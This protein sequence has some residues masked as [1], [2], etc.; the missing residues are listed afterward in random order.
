VL[1]FIIFAAAEVIEGHLFK[2]A[3]FLLLSGL[4]H[5]ALA[6]QMALIVAAFYFLQYRFREFKSLLKCILLLSV[7]MA[8]CVAP[9]LILRFVN[10]DQLSV[11]ELMSGMRQNFHINSLSLKLFLNYRIPTFVG[12]MAV[13]VQ[14]MRHHKKFIPNFL[15]F[16][17][18]SLITTILFAFLHLAGFIWSVPRLLQL[19][20]L[21]STLI[22]IMLT[23]PLPVTYLVDKILSDRFLN[24]CIAASILF[25]FSL[26][27]WGFFW[28]PLLALLLTDISEGHL[29]IFKFDLKR[30][31]QS[32]FYKA[33]KVIFL[34]W[35][36]IV[37]AWGAYAVLGG[38]DISSQ[39]FMSI[40]IP[41]ALINAKGY[42]CALTFAVVVGLSGW[43]PFGSL[44]K[45]WQRLTQSVRFSYGLISRLNNFMT[46]FHSHY[47]PVYLLTAILI[48][49]AVSKA[50]KIGRETIQPAAR[51]NYAAQLW[52]RY[53]TA[54]DAKFLVLI[55]VPWRTVSIRNTIFLDS[56]R[57]YIYSVSRQGKKIFDEI[58]RFIRE[59][60]PA[61]KKI[62]E[63]DALRMAEHFGRDYIVC[64]RD[65]PLNLSEVYRNDYVVIYK[66]SKS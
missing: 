36:V 11:S 4:I 66:I 1:P 63:V 59:I 40:L 27:G 3:F 13:T 52:A 25:L 6:I 60:N 16:C 21:R 65:N 55:A 46:V 41:G 26:F 18:A 8:F 39:P 28:A 2:G 50:Y 62:N 45:L 9:Q 43:Y 37:M 44:N 17:C 31:I 29:A 35:L 7:V 56:N 20:P 14:A 10:H 24:R 61:Q 32:R 64:S 42:L 47:V 53:N 15:T 5:P 12:F 34:G 49:M 38:S 22:F 33:S 23:L 51:A 54:D 58:N 57:F 48:T 30:N 19:V